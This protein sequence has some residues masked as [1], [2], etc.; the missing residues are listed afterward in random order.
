MPIALPDIQHNLEQVRER[1]HRAAAS[2]GRD[3]DSIRLIAVSKQMT[4]AHINRAMAAGQHL[5]GENTVQEAL[6]KL[7]LIQDPQTEWHFIGHLQT[8]KARHIADHFAWLHTLDSLKLA[9]KLAHYAE[10]AG[11]QLRVLIQVNIS[12]D[13]DKFGLSPEGVARFADEFLGAGL[14]GISLHGL[15]TIGQ[16]DISGSERRRE[17]VRLRKLGDACATRFGT[18]HFTELSMGMSDDYEIAISEGATMV[19]IGSALFG[20]RPQLGS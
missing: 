14:S 1:I 2:A 18:D 8:N 15:M 9:R 19:R 10:V 17:F 4:A 20:P 3:P 7:P 16:R 13:P 5:F 6:T 12:A 11:R